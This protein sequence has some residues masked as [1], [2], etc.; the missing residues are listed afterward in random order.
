MAM[1]NHVVMYLHF[2]LRNIICCTIRQMS[3]MHHCDKNV[4]GISM[5]F[6]SSA[7][8]GESQHYIYRVI[9]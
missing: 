5:R 9:Q 4:K 6:G 7:I 3:P 8:S 1:F 2:V